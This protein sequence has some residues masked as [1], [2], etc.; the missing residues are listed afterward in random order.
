MDINLA[1]SSWDCA[2]HELGVQTKGVRSLEF[3]QRNGCLA[4]ASPRCSVAGGLVH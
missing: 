2:R 4:T 3:A 1:F